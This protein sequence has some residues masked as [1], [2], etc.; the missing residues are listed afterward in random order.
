M[1]GYGDPDIGGLG[2]GDPN[3]DTPIADLG[4]GDPFYSNPDNLG[5]HVVTNQVNHT[6]GAEVILKGENLSAFAPFQISV[7]VG[8]KNLLFTSG[9]AGQGFAIYPYRNDLYCY[10]PPAPVGTYPLKIKYGVH[11]SNEKILTIKYVTDNKG[12]E[13]YHYR[14][15]FPSH[16][17]TGARA[18]ALDILDE[19]EIVREESALENLTDTIGRVFQEVSGVAM[20]RTRLFTNRNLVNWRR[21]ILLLEKTRIYQSRDDTILSIAPEESLRSLSSLYSLK[22]FDSENIP[23]SSQRAFLRQTVYGARGTYTGFFASIRSFFKHSEIILENVT[24]NQDDLSLSIT[25]TDFDLSWAQDRFI[26]VER[27][28]GALEVH[29]GILFS[30]NT[31]FLSQHRVA[32]HTGDNEGGQSAEIVRCTLL[33]FRLLEPQPNAKHANASLAKQCTV[34][35]EVSSRA[36]LEVPPSY[37]RENGDARSSD[38]QG[39]QMRSLTEPDYGANTAEPYPLYYPSDTSTSEYVRILFNSLLAS[40]IFLEFKIKDYTA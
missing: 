30:N 36:V 22:W 12:Y 38:P 14:S 32:S 23:A 29:R 2:F 1:N 37:Y 27:A 4:Y 20:T 16:Y 33:P 13:R 6:G 40:G 9:F 18:S 26:E 8:N 17:Q 5:I 39:L 34:I 21:F 3:P 31:I 10:A 25:H 19:G 28:S 11:F 15:L 7:V 24:L 35:L